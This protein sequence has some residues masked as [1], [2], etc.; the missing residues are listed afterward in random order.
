MSTHLYKITAKKELGKIAKGMSVEIV[1]KNASRKPNQREIIDSINAKYGAN[2]AMS[3]LSL[4]N[5]DII[6]L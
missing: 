1:I 6:A 5:F 3:G 4:S 2:T